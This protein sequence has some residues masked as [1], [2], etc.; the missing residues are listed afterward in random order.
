VKIDLNDLK[1]VILISVWYQRHL[2]TSCS[3]EKRMNYWKMR[4]SRGK[5]WKIRRL[6]LYQFFFIVIKKLQNIG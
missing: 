4:K 6:I 3:C 5:W 1:T 2:R